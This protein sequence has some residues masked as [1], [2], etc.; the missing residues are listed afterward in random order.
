MSEFKTVAS[1][2][3]FRTL[4]ESEVLLGYLDGFDGLPCPGNSQSRSFVH[5][6]RNGM[7]DAGHARPDHAQMMLAE[8]FGCMVPCT[9]H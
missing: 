2:A 7:A 6:W 1:I 8:E 5:G 3:D 4:D 9:L